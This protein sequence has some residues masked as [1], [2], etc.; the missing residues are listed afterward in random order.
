MPSLRRKRSPFAAGGSI[1]SAS[2][3]AGVAGRSSLGAPLRR[4]GFDYRHPR[5]FA[6]KADL[7]TAPRRNRGE[8]GSKPT[9]STI[10]DDS[11]TGRAAAS[12]AEDAGSS[13]ARSTSLRGA[14]ARYGS[15]SHRVREGYRAE[16][17]RAKAGR[18][19]DTNQRHRGTHKGADMPCKQVRRGALP[20]CSTNH[21]PQASK[22]HA[23]AC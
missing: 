21:S 18:S 19:A 3:H 20:R 13:P 1:P 11:S 5:Q 6:R 15:A 8:V 9:P 23:A 17:R 22:V 16:A 7:V 4:R 10:W 12:Q 2:H 14:C